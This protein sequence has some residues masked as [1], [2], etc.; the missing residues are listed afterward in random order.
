MYLSICEFSGDCLL[1]NVLPLGFDG[2]A[3]GLAVLPVL[4]T[5]FRR[6]HYEYDRSVYFNRCAT[7]PNIRLSQ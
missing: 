3:K 2:N 5:P 7:S 4:K 1:E 6:S